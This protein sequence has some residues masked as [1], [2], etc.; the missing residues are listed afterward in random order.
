MILSSPWCCLLAV[1]AL[2]PWV[3]P[4]RGNDRVQNTL[5]SLLF[6]MLALALTQ[7]RFRASD[8][9]VDRV[10]ILDRSAS[11]VEQAHQSI[12][13]LAGFRSCGPSRPW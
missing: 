7:P 8:S 12:T 11:V 9:Q 1:L 13:S 5:R 6:L 4:W 2:L 3:G 10:L